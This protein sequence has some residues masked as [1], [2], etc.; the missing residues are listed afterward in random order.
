MENGEKNK[1]LF[2]IITTVVVIAYLVFVF[3]KFMY[4]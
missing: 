4:F 3:I 1:R 2:D